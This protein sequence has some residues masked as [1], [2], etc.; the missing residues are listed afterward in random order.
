[1][2]P[3]AAED[4]DEVRGLKWIDYNDM[5]FMLAVLFVCNGSTALHA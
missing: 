4:N 3:L 2:K 5:L 1:M